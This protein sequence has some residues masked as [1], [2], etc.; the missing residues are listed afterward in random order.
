MFSLTDT[1]VAIATPAGRGGIGIVRLSGE[2]APEL[3]RTLL[4][5]ERALR[6]RHATFGHVHGEGLAEVI[7]HVVVTWFERPHSYTMED[8]VEI[9]AH[10]NPMVLQRI[11]ALAVRGGARLAEP[12]EFTLR[13]HLNGRLDLVQAEAVADLVAAV[14]PLQA[15]AAMDQ[16]EGTLTT[17]LG[18]IDARLFDLCARL[19][20]SLDFPDEGF[21]F[22]S[23][24]DALAELGKVRDDLTSLAR[25]G[26]A[27]RVIR[28]GSLVAIL[29]R[30]NAGKS[31]LFNALVGSARAIVTSVAG[32][33]RDLLT[34]LV[35]VHGLAITFVDTAGLREAKDPIEIEGVQRAKQARE[36]AALSLIVLDGSQP[37]EADDRIL[38]EETKDRIRLVVVNKIDLPAAWSAREVPDALV[39]VSA[40][41]RTGLD[42]LRSRT[43][44]LLTGQERWRD[45]PAI[46]NARHL[47][48]VEDAVG[49][50]GQAHRALGEG[51]SEELVLAELAVARTSLEA[52]AGA[53]TP[54]DLLRHIFANFCIGK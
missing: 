23:R 16:L 50:V 7:D 37:L 12:G 14:T 2:L 48:H 35:D 5:R 3:A 29:G 47:S 1:I 49:I 36:I 46:S 52:I 9:S 18:R 6:P 11:V 53:R 8:V 10:G 17:V 21:H 42:E 26:R 39:R 44:E 22:V 51:A 43:V 54:D 15:R 41:D 32:T 13:A 4:R 20:A 30:P 33:T 38:L 40:L 34:E 25:E 19:E 27:G 45:A 28:E 24:Q 31:S